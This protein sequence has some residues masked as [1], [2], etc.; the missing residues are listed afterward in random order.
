MQS[1]KPTVLMGMSSFALHLAN[2]A[3]ARSVKARHL[4]EA[5]QVEAANDEIG[6]SLRLD[7]ES[8]E[9]NREAARIFYRQ[10]RMDDSARYF[11]KAVSLFD[12]D[13]HSWG[14]LSS[15]YA[16]LDDR[17][18]MMRS[19]RMMVAQAERALAEDPSNGAALGIIAGGLATLGETERAKEWI[20]RALARIETT[21]GKL[22]RPSDGDNEA[23][24]TRLRTAH[25]TLRARVEGAI[26]QI[27]MLLEDTER[28]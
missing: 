9:V 15:C 1:L 16:A 18:G 4:F 21:A 22:G 11:E 23:E 27:D 24:L 2:I 13:F 10:R 12:T 5:G 26:G 25:Q 17:E 3:E 6:A 8:W 14:M 20:E 7:P 19:A 28:R